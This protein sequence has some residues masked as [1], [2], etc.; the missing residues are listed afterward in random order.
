MRI[1]VTGGT[2][3]LG[4]HVAHLLVLKGHQVRLLGRDMRDVADVLALGAEP[5]VADLRHHTAII[6]ACAGV[7]AVIHA[8]ALSTPWGRRADF[9][10]TNVGGTE[11]V[12]AGC[13]RQRVQRLIYISS[14]SVTFA[15]HHVI[16][17]REDVPFPRHFSSWYAE[18]KK[19][20]EDRVRTVAAQL[21][22]II[23]RPKAIFGPGDRALLPRM[24]AAAQR[25]R[26]PQ[27]GDGRNHVDLTYVE[28]VAHAIQLALTARAAI[29]HTYTI[30][31]HEHIALWPLIR[32]LLSARGLAT[33]LRRIPLP[34]ALLA[35]TVMEALARG[36][37]REPLLTRYTAQLLACTQTYDTQAAQRDLGYHPLVTVAE[38][39]RRTVRGD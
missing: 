4:R 7:D 12:I 10:A 13:L 37:N 1:L 29:G 38:G 39:V 28:N 33:N 6:A 17:Q 14:P 19:L 34:A 16:A 20:G 2:G 26:L 25:G 27:I 32:E 24:L 3:F 8:G 35:A 22:T 15:G 30:T 9:I 18:S 36:T 31:N 11:A 5:W 21:E 23:L